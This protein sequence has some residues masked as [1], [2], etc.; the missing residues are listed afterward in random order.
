M[1]ATPVAQFEAGALLA[2]AA[3]ITDNTTAIQAAIGSGEIDIQGAVTKLLASIPK[4]GGIE[5]T[6][7]DPIE[8]AVFA[9]VSAYI[10]SLFA[11]YT[12][13]QIVAFAVAQLQAEAA[14]LNAGTVTGLL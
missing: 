13:A 14:R 7:V 6:I 1:P 2:L 5:G 10:G 11:K 12:P 8:N 9:A 3:I 4:P